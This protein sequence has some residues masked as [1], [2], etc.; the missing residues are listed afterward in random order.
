MIRYLLIIALLLTWPL[1]PAEG[2]Y[3]FRKPALS[4]TQIAFSFAGDL[5]IV[6]R[7]GGEAV[8]LTSGPGIETDAHFSP[9]GSQIALTGEYDGNVDV[10]V[11]PATGGV[12]RRLTWHP[13]FDTATGWTAD[14]KRV[15]FRSP[16]SNPNGIPRLYSV[17]VEGGF[18]SE[19]PL[20]QVADASFSPDGSQVAYVP[21]ES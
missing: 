20:P 10:F 17:P 7:A 12:P 15:L 8:R 21:L 2:P 14:G 11:M 4:Q 5:W 1:L 9:D 6:N 3:L 18:P 19:Y 16:R 13:A